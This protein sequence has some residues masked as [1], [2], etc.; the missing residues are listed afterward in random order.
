M[1]TFSVAEH[2]QWREEKKTL[3]SLLPNI[4]YIPRDV[5]I[6]D[7]SVIPKKVVL[8][9]LLGVWMPIVLLSLYGNNKMHLAKVWMLS[10]AKP[11]KFWQ[12]WD[13]RGG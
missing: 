11:Q 7:A 6:A 9:W 3:N 4:Q 13:E 1:L 10:A 12:I 8:P 2:L 5:T